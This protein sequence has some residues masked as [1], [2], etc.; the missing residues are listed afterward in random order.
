MYIRIW[1]CDLSS[2]VLNWWSY[3]VSKIVKRRKIGKQVKR[4]LIDWN[5]SLVRSIRLKMKT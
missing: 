1:I 4:A 5:S 2:I 3:N